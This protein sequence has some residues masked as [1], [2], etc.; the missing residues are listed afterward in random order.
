MHRIAVTMDRTFYLLVLMVLAEHGARAENEERGSITDRGV[1][2]DESSVKLEELSFAEEPEEEFG[3]GV[4][5]RELRHECGCHSGSWI[6]CSF[7][8]SSQCCRCVGTCT[9]AGYF[10]FCA[11]EGRSTCVHAA[12]SPPPPPPWSLDT[13]SAVLSS[14]AAERVM[15]AAPLYWGGGGH[16]TYTVIVGT[17]LTF[18]IVVAVNTLWLMPDRSAWSD[19]DF[20]NAVQLAGPYHGGGTMLG[21]NLY[22][23]VV[24]RPGTLYFACIRSDPVPGNGLHCRTLGQKA[25]VDIVEASPPPPAPPALL[26]PPASSPSPHCLCG[27]RHFRQGHV[28]PGWGGTRNCNQGELNW[29]CPAATSNDGRS[30]MYQHCCVDNE[31]PS[32]LLSSSPP[33][34]P[35][36]PLPP[37]P[38][39]SPLPPPPPPPSPAPPASSPSPHCLCGTRH[40]RQGHVI[41]KKSNFGFKALRKV[42]Q[43]QICGKNAAIHPIV[44]TSGLEIKFYPILTLR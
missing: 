6:K 35:P 30:H 40:F 32:P 26:Q 16:P 15:G 3:H 34:P 17:K 18:N 44:F 7:L 4:H 28:I 24:T 37:P 23:A 2:L 5:G 29:A 39:P 42:S 31:P 36:S 10:G 8:G 20:T 9:C 22:Q 13:S 12:T 25:Q 19:C 27:T 43:R 1:A 33:S 38:P 41:Q 14:A 11:A 21:F